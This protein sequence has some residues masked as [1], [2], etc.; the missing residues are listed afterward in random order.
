MVSSDSKASKLKKMCFKSRFFTVMRQACRCERTVLLTSPCPTLFCLGGLGGTP[1]RVRSSSDGSHRSQQGTVGSKERNKI[2]LFE[3]CN[4]ILTS[5][6]ISID[7]RQHFALTCPTLYETQQ[8][9]IHSF[10]IDGG[11]VSHQYRIIL[12]IGGSSFDASDFCII[13]LCFCLDVRRGFCHSFLLFGSLPILPV[14]LPAMLIKD[15][16]IS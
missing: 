12:S 16:A 10:C 2:L 14:G 13:F 1:G 9:L 4:L 7:P 11:T 15:R 6:F 5:C 8:A 3:V